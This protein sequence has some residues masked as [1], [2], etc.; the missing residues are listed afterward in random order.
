M[1]TPTPYQAGT[2]QVTLSCFSSNPDY[3]I[4]FSF[5][6]PFQIGLGGSTIQTSTTLPDGSFGQVNGQVETQYLTTN[7]HSTGLFYCEGSNRGLTTRV[8]NI[9]H[10]VISKYITSTTQL[11]L[12]LI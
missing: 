4:A 12:Q 2:S 10:S 11:Q 1:V 7:V 5:G 3:N 6:R 9:I 8:Y